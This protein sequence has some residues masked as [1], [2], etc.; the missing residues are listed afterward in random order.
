MIKR[1][2]ILV[3]ACILIL[4]SC[5]DTEEKI[6]INK[7]NSGD[8]TLTIDMGKLLTIMEQ[9]GGANDAAKIKEKKDSTLYFKS[10][11]DTSVALTAKEKEMYRE[12]S[13]RMQVN[14]EAKQMKVIIN[15]PFKNIAQLPEMRS[16]YMAVID[17]LHIS[18]KLNNKADDDT[19]TS[20]AAPDLSKN[21]DMLNPVQQAYT[22][23]ASQGKIANTLTNRQLITD[24]VLNDSTMQ[25]MQQMTLMMGEMNYKTVIVLPSA[26]KIYTGNQ[27]ILSNDKKTI[28]F[29][30]TFTDML[31]KPEKAG[32]TVEY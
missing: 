13:L 27:S 10:Y 18:N 11:V 14:E 7:N 28:T 1:I 5:L 23:T 19:G 21:K 16:S 24:K 6:V 8:Y 9:M 26:V 12:G 2:C 31:N 3:T 17:K 20:D 15:L 4:T 29:L 32:Y 30:N 25:M 22:F